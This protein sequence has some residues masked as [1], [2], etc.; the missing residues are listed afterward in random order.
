MLTSWNDL[1]K[2]KKKTAHAY[3]SARIF[4]S[5]LAGKLDKFEQRL[6]WGDP[7]QKLNITVLDA[8]YKIYF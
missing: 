3:L 4:L 5:L 6:S 8:H 2:L 1:L 7:G